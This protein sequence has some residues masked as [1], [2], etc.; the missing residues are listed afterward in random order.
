MSNLVG[1]REIAAAAILHALHDTKMPPP[2]DWQAR[3]YLS[4]RHRSQK[5]LRRLRRQVN[6]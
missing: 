2:V 6:H 5:K 4:I 1:L 3:T